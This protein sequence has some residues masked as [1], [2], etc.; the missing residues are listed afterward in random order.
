VKDIELFAHAAC[1]AN[2]RKWRAC[3]RSLAS[4]LVRVRACTYLSSSR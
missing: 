1:R 2:A 3:G 4:M